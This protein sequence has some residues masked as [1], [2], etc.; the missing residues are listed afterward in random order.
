MNVLYN[1]ILCHIW[2]VALLLVQLDNWVQPSTWFKGMVNWRQRIV[3]QHHSDSRFRYFLPAKHYTGVT[4]K[5]ICLYV[6]CNWFNSFLFTSELFYAYSCCLLCSYWILE[7][8]TCWMCRFL[9][10]MH[11]LLMTVLIMHHL[12]HLCKTVTSFLCLI[13]W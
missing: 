11:I 6:S 7:A 5:L 9:R 13:W 4:N 10:W 1:S 12:T 8:L 2:F 3:V